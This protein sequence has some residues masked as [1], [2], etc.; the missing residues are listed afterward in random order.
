MKR[1]KWKQKIGYYEQGLQ[2]HPNNKYG[3]T[4]LQHERGFRG[5][6]YGPASDC[7]SWSQE[8]VLKHNQDYVVKYF[9]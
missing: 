8:E 1:K 7:V 9:D 2:G 6:T 5:G 4:Q 3:G